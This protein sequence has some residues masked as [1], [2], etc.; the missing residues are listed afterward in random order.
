MTSITPD[1]TM[2]PM[3]NDNVRAAMIQEEQQFLLDFLS[4]GKPIPQMLSADFT[5]VNSTLAAYYGMPA[6]TG[7]ALVRVPTAGSQRVGGLLTLGAYLAGESN[8]TRTSPVKRGLFVLDRLLCSAP[9]PPPATVNQN[10]DTGSGLENLPIR[11]RLAQ[12]QKLGSGC[13]ACH[14]I[15]DNIG[16]SLENFDGVGRYRTSDEYGP[17]DNSGTLNTANGPTMFNGVSGLSGI[18]AADTRF[19][20]CLVQKMLTF[21]IGRDFSRDTDIKAALAAAAGGQSASLGGTLQAVVMSDA[22][23]SRRAALQT[24]VMP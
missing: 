24:E 6:V 7:T 14:S 4:N 10:I 8:P 2:Y 20:P 13:A 15:M 3:F 9:P 1:K 22:F 18:L 23:R 16:L 19:V 11:Q 21:S 17:I 5:Y 12:H